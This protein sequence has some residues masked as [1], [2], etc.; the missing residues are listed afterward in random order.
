MI[1][2]LLQKLLVYWN[3]NAK[4]DVVYGTPSHIKWLANS[5]SDW[6]LCSETCLPNWNWRIRVRA[7][8]NV[9]SNPLVCC[10]GV[11]YAIP[12]NMLRRVFTWIAINSSIYYGFLPTIYVVTIVT[13]TAKVQWTDK[14]CHKVKHK[15]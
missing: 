3:N 8:E 13:A 2:I 1:C 6:I 10:L 4:I 12:A 11:V 15:S 7:I 14:T 5:I 9:F